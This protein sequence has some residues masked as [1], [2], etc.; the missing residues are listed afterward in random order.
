MGDMLTRD[1]LMSA[2]RAAR[3]GLYRPSLGRESGGDGEMAE[4]AGR[5]E[6]RAREGVQ[7]S[8]LVEQ[9]DAACA[10]QAEGEGSGGDGER[11]EA[12]GGVERHARE[13]DLDEI[14]A[15]Y[16]MF[17][18]LNEQEATQIV[19]LLQE[20]LGFPFRIRLQRVPAIERSA[21]HKFEDFISALPESTNA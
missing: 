20:R 17:R 15:N 2:H 4:A 16:V 14:E 6:R 21:P 13:G 18:A 9:R 11:A 19:A 5:A 10:A 8:A 12:G 7:V 1:E 3:G